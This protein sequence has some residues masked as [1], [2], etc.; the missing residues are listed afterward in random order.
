M[1]V[2]PE[3]KEEGQRKG[4]TK[5]V[6]RYE[7]GW[8]YKITMIGWLWMDIPGVISSLAEDSAT[9]KKGRPFD[10]KKRNPLIFYIKLCESS[11]LKQRQ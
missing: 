10:E 1:R 3:T 5:A 11:K 2:S 9:M 6:K 7:V 4:G 8:E